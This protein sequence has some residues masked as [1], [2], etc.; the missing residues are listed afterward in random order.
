MHFTC[1]YI[2][3]RKLLVS[4]FLLGTASPDADRSYGGRQERRKR[5]RKKT[6]AADLDNLKYLIHRPRLLHLCLLL[7][8]GRLSNMLG[9]TGTVRKKRLQQRQAAAAAAAVVAANQNSAA[10]AL[11]LLGN[12]QQRARSPLVDRPRPPTSPGRAHI[13]LPLTDVVTPHRPSLLEAYQIL[14]VSTQSLIVDYSQ[15][16]HG[17]GSP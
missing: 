6:I 13:Q 5:E 17:Q 7:S 3:T 14:K 12:N 11:R 4:N 10:N 8:G 9:R 1:F 16:D 15:R 2:K